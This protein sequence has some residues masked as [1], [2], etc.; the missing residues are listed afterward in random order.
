MG[1]PG[2][3]WGIETAGRMGLPG[4]IIGRAR[5][6]MASPSL[7]LEELLADLERTERMLAAEREDLIA[8]EEELERLVSSYRSHLDHLEQNREELEQEARREALD[9]V[10]S[11]RV[12]MERL[13]KDIRTAQAERKVIARSKRRSRKR[14]NSSRKRS[15]LSGRKL[16]RG[17]S[18]QG[19]S[20]RGSG[21]RS[22]AS[23]GMERSSRPK[24]R[25]GYWWNCREG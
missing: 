12:E 8:R 16:L 1:I 3:S 25:L 11:T 19:I 4:E 14:P 2:R 9:I 13:V 6:K 15:G 20:S 17:P 21:S 22:R 5:E 24:G 7:R 10:K 23:A 18:I